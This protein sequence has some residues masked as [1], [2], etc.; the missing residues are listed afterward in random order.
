MSLGEHLQLLLL[1]F[2]VQQALCKPC[3]LELDVWTFL[4]P[5]LCF[6]LLFAGAPT[7]LALIC[8]LILLLLLCHCIETAESSL[9]SCNLTND[10]SKAL[11]QPLLPG[12]ICGSARTCD[13]LTFFG[14]VIARCFE[15]K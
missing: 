7:S 3:M 1:L 10:S 9:N 13:R 4:W 6:I 2:Q 15:S 11:L 12:S 5:S 14:S 8:I